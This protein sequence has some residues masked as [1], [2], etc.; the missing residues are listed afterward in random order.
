[1]DIQKLLTDLVAIPS[2]NRMGRGDLPPSSSRMVEYVERWLRARGIRSERQPVPGGEENLIVRVG[3]PNAQAIVFDAHTDTVP[4]EGWEDRAFI[5]RVE[6]DR[7]YGR[8]AC[9]TKGCLTAMLVALS[10]AVEAGGPA[11]QVVLVATADEEYLRTGV[12]AFL[13]GGQR[14]ALAIVGEPTRL[15]PVVACKG[16]AR[17]EMT[18][19]GRTAHSS[20][21]GEGLNA[22]TRLA[23]LLRA[24]EAYNTN[25]AGVKRHPLVDPPTLT[26]TM[27]R[28]GSAPNVVPASCTVFVDLRTLPNEDAE[29]VMREARDFLQR[30]C[31]FPLDHGSAQLWKGADLPGEHPLVG[32]VM[33]HCRAVLGEAAAIEPR[34][35]NYGCH[36]SDYADAGIPAVVLGPGDIRHA[37]AVDE[38]IEVSEVEAAARIYHDLMTDPF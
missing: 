19:P 24:V 3:A 28:G 36:A 18:I 21:P 29:A 16:A 23:E 33:R 27:V 8:G 37:H 30:R 10:R 2:V 35:V 11:N 32:R 22:I 15:E 26:P 14:A 20:R 17:W 7:V 5:P 9:D 31:S 34:G 6:G 4:A 12:R 13:Q 38:Y 1:M 25:V